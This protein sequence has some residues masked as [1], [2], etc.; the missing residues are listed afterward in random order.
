MNYNLGCLV[1]G[2]S[3]GNYNELGNTE[4]A[5]HRSPALHFSVV[6]VFATLQVPRVAKKG[7]RTYCPVSR[8]FF[9]SGGDRFCAR[10]ALAL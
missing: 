6:G 10:P 4:G 2:S 7:S 3:P 8:L 5:L 1:H 9:S